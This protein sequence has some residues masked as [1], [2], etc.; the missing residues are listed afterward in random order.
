MGSNG[1]KC[2]APGWCD[3]TDISGHDGHS[4]HQCG[5]GEEA[6]DV[7]QGIDGVEPPPS[8]RHRSIHVDDTIPEPGTGSVQPSAQSDGG[9]RGA[10]GDT[11]S[12]APQFPQCQDAHE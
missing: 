6:I 4:V 2:G 8:I 11:F 12:T 1:F 10:A 5:G 7:R 9:A 3:V